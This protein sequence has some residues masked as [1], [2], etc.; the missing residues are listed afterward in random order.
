MRDQELRMIQII[1]KCMNDLRDVF[2]TQWEDLN[3]DK[4]KKLRW[5]INRKKKMLIKQLKCTIATSFISYNKLTKNQIFGF[6][7][8]INIYYL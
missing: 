6:I 4:N 8:E 2:N 7:I 1:W 5:Q 3:Y